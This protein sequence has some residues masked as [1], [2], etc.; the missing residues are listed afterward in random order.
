M[1]K[2]C[3]ILA[4][5]VLPAFPSTQQRITPAPEGPFQIAG[6]HILDARGRTFLPKG[7]ELPAFH[8]QTV[9]QDTRNASDFGPHSATSLAA[10]RL[11]FNMNAV[12][13]PVDVTE[14]DRPDFFPELVKLVNRAHVTEL[15]VILV[16][17][18]PG[19]AMPSAKTAAFWSRSART[20]RD[21]PNVWFDLFA[22]SS[23]VPAADWKA[24]LN[25]LLAAVRGAGA[26]QPVVAMRADFDGFTAL[27]DD[28][29]VIYET[30]PRYLTGSKPPGALAARVPLIASGWDLDFQNP[31]SCAA[32]PTDPA[33]ATSLVQATL[34]D[35]DERAIGWT[36]SVFEPGRLIK[37]LADH[38]ATSLENG[39]TCGHVTYP[40]PGIGRV[41]QAHLRAT[42]ERALFVVGAAGG[43]DVP[44]GGFAIA[45]G[46]VMAS[47]DV[48]ASGTRLALHAGGITVNVTD[49]RGVMR[50]AGILWASAGWGQVNFVVPDASA[51][52]PA[53]MTIVR[54]D[55][56]RSSAN[57][58]IADTA[59]G[60]WTGV[61]CRGPASGYSGVARA[62]LSACAGG[63]CKTIPIAL[64]GGPTRVVVQGSGFR[65]AGSTADIEITL[66]GVRVR[67]IAFG[68]TA[69]AGIDQVVLEIPPSL[70]GTGEA[71][72]ICHI[73]GRVSNPVRLNVG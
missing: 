21:D 32:V 53:R 29:A 5:A 50:P 38:D 51:T 35:Y 36:V 24:S 23:D 34:Q 72:L 15:L 48:R 2:F 22:F 65:H 62:P 11:R 25:P 27:L 70:R 28:P 46:P 16:A 47:R 13:I 33:A 58:T 60:L 49:A 68:P 9:A 45:Y 26:R 63:E 20:F 1:S 7:T 31:D 39:W 43:I 67:V 37:D 42:E 66:G 73:K 12:R 54:D 71:D 6:N 19:A 14:S 4:C 57:I 30:A 69:D 17:K 44:R 61:S 41:V 52:G 18:E 8:P 10:I 56:S 64:S 3:L 40:A 55:G 59:P